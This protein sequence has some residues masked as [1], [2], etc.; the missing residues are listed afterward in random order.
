MKLLDTCYLI[1]L[2]RGDP[3]AM[4]ISKDLDGAATSAV[5]LYELIFGVHLGSRNRKRR[6]EEAET[7]L[8]RLEVL[9]FDGDSARL[10]ARLMS[11]LISEG[12][13]GDSLDVFTA[14]VGLSH[15]C[16]V[17]VTRNAKHFDRIQGIQTETY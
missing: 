7:L 8:S 10:A 12:T 13:P 1:D 5:N 6:M 16:S 17:V 3:E 4:L 2:L 14:A 15:G 9:P 11:N